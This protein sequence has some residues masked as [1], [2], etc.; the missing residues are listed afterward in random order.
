M[1]IKWHYRYMTF[2]FNIKIN[3]HVIRV[4]NRYG[5]KSSEV[6]VNNKTYKKNL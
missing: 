5:K 6:K 4:G 1:Q 3:F 2:I